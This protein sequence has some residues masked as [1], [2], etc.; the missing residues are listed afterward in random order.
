ML[1]QGYLAQINVA[2]DTSRLIAQAFPLRAFSSWTVTLCH[3]KL[4]LSIEF[5]YRQYRHGEKETGAYWKVPL[6]LNTFLHLLVTV[7]VGAKYTDHAQLHLPNTCGWSSESSKKAL[8]FSK[9]L[10][11]LL[12]YFTAFHYSMSRQVLQLVLVLS[13]KVVFS[14]FLVHRTCCHWMSS[15]YPRMGGIHH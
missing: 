2:A 12:S 4:M 7:R 1:L 8:F 3:N 6:I 9:D 10:V 15:L 11:H 13:V 5:N 14:P